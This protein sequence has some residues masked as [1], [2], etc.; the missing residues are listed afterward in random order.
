MS[1]RCS[2]G[3]IL[4]AGPAGL[5][6]AYQLSKGRIPVEALKASP[7]Y[8]AGISRTVRYKG[9]RFDIDGHRFFSKSKEVEDLWTGIPGNEFRREHVISSIPIQDLG[10][11]LDPLPPKE[12]PVTYNMGQTLAAARKSI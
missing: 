8:V 7:T 1:K 2:G 9:F 11:F 10:R 12:A 5:T 6:A 3:V 4:G